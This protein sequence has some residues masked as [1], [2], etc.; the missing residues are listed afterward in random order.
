MTI[1]K[2]ISILNL[3]RNKSQTLDNWILNNLQERSRD[4][5]QTIS[6]YYSNTFSDFEKQDGINLFLGIF[7]RVF[8]YSYLFFRNFI[9]L[10]EKFVT[11]EIL[12]WKFAHDEARGMAAEAIYAGF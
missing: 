4:V 7:R 8:T 2:E 12:F 11:G 10:H 6:R 9:Q 5:L 1:I 3:G